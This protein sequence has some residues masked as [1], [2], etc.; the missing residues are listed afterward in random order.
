MNNVP[1]ILYHYTSF[2]AFKKIME[3]ET[4][5]ATHYS[6]LNDWSEVQ[7][8]QKMLESN[9]KSDNSHTHPDTIPLLLDVV[10]S[11]GKGKLPIFLFSLSEEG[12]LRCSSR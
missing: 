3:S 1:E 4:I 7:M 10:S 9:L 2:D 8:G 11:F 6:E 12:D 5:R